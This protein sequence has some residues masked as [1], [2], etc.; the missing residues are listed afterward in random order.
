MFN[1]HRKLIGDCPMTYEW[2]GAALAVSAFAAGSTYVE[3]KK[4]T[5]AVKESGKKQEELLKKQEGELAQEEKE[6][7]Q[8]IGRSRQGRR[9]LLYK[10]GDEMGVDK[11]TTLGG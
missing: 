4:Q 3:Q 5:K 7:M 9:S 8:R 1:L 11:S 6:R 10:E 2:A